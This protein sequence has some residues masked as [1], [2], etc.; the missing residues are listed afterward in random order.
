MEQKTD[1]KKDETKD[2]KKDELG[3]ELAP[4]ER[5]M[6]MVVKEFTSGVGEPRL[7]DF[8]RRLAQ[9]YFIALDSTLKTAEEKRQKSKV[10]NNGKWE[11][12]NPS[13]IGW[14]TINMERL[15]RD[16]VSAARVG[17]DPAQKNHIAM[18][19]FKNNTTGKYDI[20]FIEG[21]R[22]VEVKATKYG[23][24]VPDAVTVE[25][26]YSTDKFKAIRKDHNH[27]FDSYEF[28][29]TDSF[30]RGDIVGGFYYYLYKDC[31]EKNRLVVF[32]IKDIL[33]RKPKHAAVEFWGGEKDIWQD[34]KKVGT[35]KV[36]GWYEEM[37]YKTVYRAAYG[38]ITIDSQKI[39]DDYLHLKQLEREADDAEFEEEINENANT[40][41]TINV[42][43]TVHPDEKE[44]PKKDD[45]EPDWAK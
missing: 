7:T 37:C 42:E 35:E 22:G 12:K 8:Q 4:S 14:P 9:N 27:P 36:E 23:L 19:P 30:K 43:A 33:K 41:P 1:Q 28:E 25:L 10:N 16:V 18:S 38:S 24:E 6:N 40:G 2:S 32:T 20:V 44:A 39:D 21:Y 34:G 26:V 45:K 13:P 29:I 3:K 5:F 11:L 17:L 31:P 15:A